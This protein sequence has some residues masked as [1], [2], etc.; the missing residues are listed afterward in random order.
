VQSDCGLHQTL[1]EESKR[2]LGLPPKVL[3]GFVGLEVLAGVKKNY[4]VLKQVG[5]GDRLVSC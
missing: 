3:P 5:H 1:I 2:S 4:S